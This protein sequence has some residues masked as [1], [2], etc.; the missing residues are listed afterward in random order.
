[1]FFVR[2]VT[3]TAYILAHPGEP[4]EPFVPN[5]PNIIVNPENI[6][7]YQSS[8]SSIRSSTLRDFIWGLGFGLS[9]AFSPRL[10]LRR[11]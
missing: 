1:M 5:E 7:N 3:L 10:L 2:Q 11:W 8:S 9:S 6:H 4:C